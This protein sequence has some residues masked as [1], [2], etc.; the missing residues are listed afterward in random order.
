MLL[1]RKIF[2]LQFHVLFVYIL[3]GKPFI[4][5][6]S[7]GANNIYQLSYRTKICQFLNCALILFGIEFLKLL[8]V[9][10]YSNANQKSNEVMNLNMVTK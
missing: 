9:K 6:I 7:F 3:A 2:C 10:F 5:L 8:S 1:P 4:Y